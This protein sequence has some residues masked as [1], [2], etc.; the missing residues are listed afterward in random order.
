MTKSQKTTVKISVED[1][2]TG[3]NILLKL[4]NMNFLAAGAFSNV[5]RGIASTDNGEKREVVIKKTWPK[6]KGKSSEEDILEMLRRL[7]H[8]NIVMLLYSYQKTHKGK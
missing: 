8:K 4:Q 6:K 2:E 3:K 5:Y 7:K 1:P